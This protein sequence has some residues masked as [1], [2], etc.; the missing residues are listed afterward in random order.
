MLHPLAGHWWTLALRAVAAIVFGILALLLPG[1][2]LLALVL[3]FGWYAI[4][5]GLL[6]LLA[7]RAAARHGGRWWWL[8]IEGLAGLA[9]GVAAIV[10]PDLTATVLMVIIGVWAIAT[11]IS[12]IVTAF[13]LRRTI[14]NELELVLAGVLSVAFG[15]V[16]VAVPGV[17]ALALVWLIG[18]YA[19]V[20]GIVL[21]ALAIRVR[22]E[23]ERAAG[24]RNVAS[25]ASS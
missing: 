13:R 14:E 7:A 8:G 25:S 9:A 24:P 4:L 16:A 10:L 15:L 2:T 19:I 5:D 6:T 21:L 1:L 18:A 23:G 11:G 12:E 20:F 17:G 3:L 22:G